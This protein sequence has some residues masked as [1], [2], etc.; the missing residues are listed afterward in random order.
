MKQIH[1]DLGKG[2]ILSAPIK[3]HLSL[4][5]WNRMTTFINA[6]IQGRKR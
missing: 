5:E 4:D 2:V 3:L 6:H 1:I